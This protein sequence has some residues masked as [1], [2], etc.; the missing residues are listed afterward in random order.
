[1]ARAH[2]SHHNFRLA[3]KDLAYHG[4]Y[5]NEFSK[6]NKNKGRLPSWEDRFGKWEN[7]DKKDS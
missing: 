5:F 3:S 4:K 2:R 6:N 1:M 7:R